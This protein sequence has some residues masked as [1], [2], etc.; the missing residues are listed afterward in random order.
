MKVRATQLGYYAHRR[1]RPGEVFELKEYAGKIRDKSQHPSKETKHT[2]TAKEQFSKRWMEEVSD[3]TPTTP[4][5]RGRAKGKSAP[6]AFLQGD[7]AGSDEADV[8]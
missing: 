6:V 3:D 4:V 5:R 8:I 7:D 2:F 1:I